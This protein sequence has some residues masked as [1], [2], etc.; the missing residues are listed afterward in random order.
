MRNKQWSEN[1]FPQI[2]FAVIKAYAT[3]ASFFWTFIAVAGMAVY[4]GGQVGTNVWLSVWSNDVFLPRNKSEALVPERLGVYAS[5]G[6]VQGQCEKEQAWAI[7]PSAFDLLPQRRINITGRQ[8]KKLCWMKGC[9]QLQQTFLARKVLRTV[10]TTGWKRIVLQTPQA[11]FWWPVRV[12]YLQRTW[13]SD[14][15]Y[16][17]LMC[18][19][20]E[21]TSVCYRWSRELF[22]NGSVC[23]QSLESWCWPRRW[24]T[25]RLRPQRNCTAS[26]CRTWC[27]V[28]WASLTRRL[29]DESS[30]ASLKM[31]TQWTP[32]C[33]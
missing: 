19:K 31:L 2:K 21:C 7:T 4:V 32:I 17:G 5:L 23:L 16:N 27:V 11:E 30:I 3:A 1:F 29:W 33:V 28:Q 13:K 8:T 10:Q 25:E 24:P 18:F 14:D 15:P 22:R 9:A 26:F 6:C 20:H 12:S